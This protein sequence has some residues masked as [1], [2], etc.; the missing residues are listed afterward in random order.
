M[1]VQ[2][3]EVPETRGPPPRERPKSREETPVKGSNA[4]ML[5]LSPCRAASTHGAAHGSRCHL[6]D[7][8]NGTGCSLGPRVAH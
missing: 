6:T 8:L 2:R 5:A 1:R 4:T 3:V 7:L